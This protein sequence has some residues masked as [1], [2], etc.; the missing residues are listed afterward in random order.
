[1]V[2]F[3]GNNMEGGNNYNPDGQNGCGVADFFN[4]GGGDNN[5]GNNN[6][7]GGNNN[8]GGNSNQNSFNFDDNNTDWSKLIFFKSKNFKVY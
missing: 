8:F 1:M 3:S 2:S 4:N 7:G 5:G 6:G